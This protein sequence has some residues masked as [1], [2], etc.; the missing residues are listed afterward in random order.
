MRGLKSTLALIAVLIGLGAYIY[1]VTWQAEDETA[2]ERVFPAVEPANIQE[3]TVKSASGDV[4]SL[5]KDGET[6][7]IIS[8]V[9]TPASTAD[10]S[11]ITYA[12]DSLEVM[13]VIDEN[14]AN[15]SEYGLAEP[16]VRIEFK[17]AEGS[18][19]GTLLLGDKTPTGG[20][21]YAKR[22]DEPR[23]FLVAEYQNSSLDKSTFAL[24]EK[25]LLRFDR[26]KI[27]GIE[28]S[29]PGRLIEIAK[30][31][32]VWKLAKPIA[33]RTDFMPIQTLLGGL[34]TGRMMSVVTEN[35]TPD[36]LQKYGLQ[37][38]SASVTITMG[39]DRATFDLGGRADAQ[40][41]Y[42]RDRSKPTVV[43]VEQS[44][45]DDL[46][47]QVADLRAKDVFEFITVNVTRA[48]FTRNGV[49]TVFERGTGGP[50]GESTWRRTTPNP[51]DVDAA[52]MDDLLTDLTGLQAQ[53]FVTS[54]ANTGLDSPALVAVIAFEGGTKEERVTFGQRGEAAYVS[55]PDDPGAATIDAAQFTEA[56][57]AL[58][59]LSK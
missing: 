12:L 34:E 43:T 56:L 35:A 49:I 18:P 53:S 20:S 2:A 22:N 39:T 38:P 5:K 6:W 33:A 50:N 1:F 15:L 25:T 24:R 14:P 51:A 21:L 30:V 26:E 23:V 9:T 13:R 27:T 41:L 58:D 4:T 54:T 28:L 46:G 37:N 45:A 19:A 36:E 47:K 11:S 55:R 59:K 16:R 32:D 40:T 8:P 57:S 17:G 3:L 52:A 44:F 48:E 7:Q 31:G 10:V 29:G 42:A